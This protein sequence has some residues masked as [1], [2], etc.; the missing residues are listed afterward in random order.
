[1]AVWQLFRC[2]GSSSIS[3]KTPLEEP[4]VGKHVARVVALPQADAGRYPLHLPLR[5]GAS[6]TFEVDLDHARFIGDT[7]ALVRADAAVRWF[8]FPGARASREFQ[9][10][11]FLCLKLRPARLSLWYLEKETMI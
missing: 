10:F 5:V 6:L 7:A 11:C 4:Q 9:V 2:L 8:K 3:F 1:M